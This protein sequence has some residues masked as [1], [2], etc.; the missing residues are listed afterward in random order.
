MPTIKDTAATSALNEDKYINKLYDDVRD[1]QK[2]QLDRNYTDNSSFL[3]SQQQGVQ[4]QTDEYLTR[5]K[6][7]AEKAAKEYEDTQYPQLSGGGAAQARLSQW[8]QRTADANALKDRQS[9]ADAEI[10]RQRQLLASQY[11]AAIRQAQA[12]NDMQRAQQLYDA[13]KAEEA[14][15][16]EYRKSAASLMAGKGDNS[17]LEALANGQLPQRDTTSDSWAEVLKNEEALNKIY[18]SNMESQRIGLEA[19]YQKALSDL[20]AARQQQTAKTDAALTKTYVDAL[21]KARNYAEVQNAYGQGSGTA[22]QARL[23]RDMGLQQDLT[24]LR[25]LQTDA[26]QKNALNQYGTS[27]SYRDALA[28]ANAANEAERAKGLFD[29][30][31]QEQQNLEKLQEFIGKEYAKKGNYEILGKLYGLTPPKSSGGAEKAPTPQK[32]SGGAEKALTPDQIAKL[33]AAASGGGGD[34]SRN[35]RTTKTVTMA[36]YAA[37]IAK[38]YGSKDAIAWVNDQSGVSQAEKNAAIAN[39]KGVDQTEYYKKRL[40]K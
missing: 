3:D 16:L 26:A 21:Q 28:R 24:D 6:V 34:D 17:I 25:L 1:S 13:A 18:D 38:E 35:T 4:N 8:N 23:A 19:E 40:G 15:L 2:Q 27:L 5:T 32:S 29:A 7:E 39:A 9:D 31:D 37:E 36:D 12:D 33:K 14:R 20:E 10:E 22:E 11:S 30:A